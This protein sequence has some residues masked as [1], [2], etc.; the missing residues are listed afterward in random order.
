MTARL[1]GFLSRC[2]YGGVEMSRQPTRF[3]TA[4]WKGMKRK[5]GL[6]WIPAMF[7]PG[8]MKAEQEFSCDLDLSGMTVYDI[9]AFHGLLTLFFASRAKT[10]VCFESNTQN[11]K[12][13]MEDLILNGIKNV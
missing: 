1:S 7:S 4:C 10:V 3:A 13:L 5:G 12:R 2:F 11:Y 8:I 6:G 9:G